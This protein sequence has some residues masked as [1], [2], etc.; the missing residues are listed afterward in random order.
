MLRAMIEGLNY[1]FLAILQA[2]ESAVGLEA[3]RVVAI[4]GP[5][6]NSFWMQNKA[7]VLGRP[8]EVPDLEE[9]VPL[10]AAILAG[11]GVGLYR[12]EA[13]ALEHV[14]RPGRTYHPDPQLTAR[15]RNWFEIY[16]QLYPALR[17]ISTQLR[18]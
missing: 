5:T 13:D 8:I 16:Q 10:G 11:I 9:A 4:G 17:Q 6:R 14:W 18:Q 15:Y 1:Q 12:D 7:D 3:E 2:M